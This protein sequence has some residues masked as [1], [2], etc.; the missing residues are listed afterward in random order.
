MKFSKRR[1]ESN[2]SKLFKM[3]DYI[4]L[5]SVGGVSLIIM[6]AGCSTSKQ[7]VDRYLDYED[8]E[9][10]WSTR[11]PG[12]RGILWKT[13]GH[14]MSKTHRFQMTIPERAVLEIFGLTSPAVV[15]VNLVDRQALLWL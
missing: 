5:F 4:R 14:Q 2:N 6:F 9:T 12:S 11:Y 13:P 3:V 15:N 10:G 7:V 8:N 1:V